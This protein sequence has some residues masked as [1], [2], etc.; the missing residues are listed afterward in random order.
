MIFTVELAKDESLSSIAKTYLADPLLFYALARY[1]G[2]ALPGKVNAGQV[3]KIP[4][5][6]SALA[7]QAAGDLGSK[8]APQ[9]PAD[10]VVQK[11][12]PDTHKIA[13]Q[14]YRKGF[15]AFE[16]HD[17]DGAIAALERSMQ[18]TNRF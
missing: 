15:M 5:T 18:A 2:I 16:R 11:P 3:I 14:E 1:N 6:A 10:A 17:L 13:E 8:G 9:T 7:A 12:K 4:K